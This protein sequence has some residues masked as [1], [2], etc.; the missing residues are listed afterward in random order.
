MSDVTP[1]LEEFRRVYEA[2]SNA[3]WRLESGHHMNLFDAALD[4]LDAARAR[5]AELEGERDEIRA[6]AGR[7]HG[8][9]GALHARVMELRAQVTARDARIAELEAAQRP[10]LGMR[11]IADTLAFI[12]L[13]IVGGLLQTEPARDRLRKDLTDAF[14]E[15]LNNLPEGSIAASRPPLGYVDGSLFVAADGDTEYRHIGDLTD[16]YAEVT[17]HILGTRRYWGGAIY[18]ST[19]T[20]EVFDATATAS[21]WV[22]WGGVFMRINGMGNS[23]PGP[24]D[25]PW[26]IEC[27][28]RQRVGYAQIDG[29]SVYLDL[30]EPS[31]P[32]PTEPWWVPER[33]RALR[34][35]IG[36]GPHP[37]SVLVPGMD[38]GLV[39]I[40]PWEVQP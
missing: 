28:Q 22:V 18:A 25:R 34:E 11:D 14:D 12:A 32:T 23:T 7:A 10:P 39:S 27:S 26:R 35:L 20:K 9:A 36:T 40:D 16:P 4:A 1:P 24:G 38:G 8:S 13:R 21:A 5:V 15:L 2:D 6:D 17:Q 31:P 19:I 37:R 3:W 33:A 29:R 30:I